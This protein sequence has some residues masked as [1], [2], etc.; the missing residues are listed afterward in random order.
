MKILVAV[1]GSPYTQKA[2]SYMVAHRAM[3]IEG[4]ELVL[5]HVTT[6]LPSNVKRHV[7]KEIVDSYYADECA[8]ATDPAKA[9]L[10]GEG[11]G[12][13]AIEHRH[14]HAPEVIVAAAKESGAGL[15]I[16]G[17]HGHGAF[18]RALMGS[19]ATRVVAESDISVLLVK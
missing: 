4:N 6:G 2:L 10:D 8:K 11:I 9:Y 14:G 12:S 16:M 5:L 18:G 3:F 15:I 19:V 17:T 7:T 13:Y 1:D